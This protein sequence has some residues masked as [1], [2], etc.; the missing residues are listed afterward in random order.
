MARPAGRTRAAAG[1]G[2]TASSIITRTSEL[3]AHTEAAR[4][5]HLNTERFRNTTYR[6]NM[7]VFEKQIVQIYSLFW[8]N[9]PMNPGAQTH[10]P[11]RRS[12]RPPFSQ[13]GHVSRHST[14]QRPSAHSD[15]QTYCVFELYLWTCLF[16]INIIIS[17]D[18]YIMFWVSLTRNTFLRCQK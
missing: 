6:R 15:A 18:P 1:Y 10:V 9:L 11:L 16:I 13:A 14:P 7:S 4:R 12:H 2:M 3:T 8:H 5:T 17:F